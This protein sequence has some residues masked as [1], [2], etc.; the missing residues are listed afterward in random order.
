MNAPTGCDTCGGCT[1][2]CR[3]GAKQAGVRG[4]LAL[5]AGY[6]AR[7]LIDAPVDRV[8]FEGRR[9]VGV[10]GRLLA[11]DD[12]GLPSEVARRYRVHARQVVIAAG[13][14]RTP[15]VLLASGRAHPWTGHG[16][17]LHPVP[18]PAG[19]MPEPWRCGRVRSRALARS[20]SSSRTRGG[21]LPGSAHGPFVIES[22]PPHPGLAG[23]AFPWSGRTDNAA[24]ME[25][26]RM[27]HRLVS[28]IG[29]RGSG[30]VSLSRTGRARIDYHIA[31]ADA[32]TANRALVEMARISR[33]AGAT[34]IV[35]V[36]D[37]GPPGS[38]RDGRQTI[39]AFRGYLGASRVADLAPNRTGLFSAHQMGSARAG[40]DPATSV[41]DPWGRVRADTTGGLVRAS[42]SPMP[43]SSRRPRRSTRR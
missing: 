20:T 25:G 37:T 31:P 23:S 19:I 13:A 15:I 2:G 35:A 34:S 42:T 24:F 8:V 26:W 32:R 4:Q 43:P 16:L 18:V 21:R 27:S 7:F 28:I 12:G 41:C 1:F 30:R 36:G 38:A 10:Q 11:L 33:A 40:A 6:G 22:A 3:V 14:L 39:V 17:R 5:A 9:A 29:D